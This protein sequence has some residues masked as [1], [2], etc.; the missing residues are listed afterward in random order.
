MSVNSLLLSLDEMG[1]HDLGKISHS[2]DG[3]WVLGDDSHFPIQ[4]DPLLNI[5]EI[6]IYGT[7]VKNI[8]RADLYAYS[9][10]N[11]A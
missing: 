8:R 11:D 6:L 10:L 1:D 7:F 4:I 9:D 2:E 3:H 5:D